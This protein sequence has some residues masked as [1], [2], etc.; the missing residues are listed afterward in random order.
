MQYTVIK[1]CTL[2]RSVVSKKSFLLS[3]V[4]LVYTVPTLATWNNAT[5]I[6]IAF[7]L[8]IV[9]IAIISS[10][11]T[12]FIEVY[13][14]GKLGVRADRT[15]YLFIA[16]LL[17]SVGGVAV[18]LYSADLLRNLHMLASPIT[19]YIVYVYLAL[20]EAFF[21]FL[22]KLCFVPFICHIKESRIK[23]I[24]LNGIVSIFFGT[25]VGTISYLQAW[26]TIILFPFTH[27]IGIAL[28]ILCIPLCLFI[29]LYFKEYHE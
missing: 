7:L 16:N 14:L 15:F 25:L 2:K 24:K 8:G 22:V 11:I 1:I 20:I 23:L 21:I 27:P 18:F 12:S 4:F 19:P 29:A 28:I 17:G 26:E 9:F 10:A 13:L 3:L 5:P 6:I